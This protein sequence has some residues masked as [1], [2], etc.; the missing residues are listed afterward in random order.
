MCVRAC[1]CV[2]KG[3]TYCCEEMIV[4]EHYSSCEDAG[5]GFC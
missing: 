5:M 2:S 3:K 4:R 1:A